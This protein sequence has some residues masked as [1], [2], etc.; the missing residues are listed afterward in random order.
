MATVA[1]LILTKA[2][3]FPHCQHETNYRWSRRDY[4]IFLA[5]FEFGGGKGGLIQGRC[6]LKMGDKQMKGWGDVGSKCSFWTAEGV[7]IR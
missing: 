2:D 5:G 3:G 6:V 4:K 1:F 7:E